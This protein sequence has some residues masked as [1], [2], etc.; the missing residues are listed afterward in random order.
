SAFGYTETYIPGADRS[1]RAVLRLC[2]D[3]DKMLNVHSEDETVK[4]LSELFNNIISSDRTLH[5]CY[6]CGTTARAMFLTLIREYRGSL[7]LT[8][9]E[10]QRMSV[11][12]KP[13][14]GDT[15]HALNMFESLS[16]TLKT[17]DNIVCICS[18]GL[19]QGS[20]HVWILEKR[21]GIVRMYQ[22]ALK[23]HLLIDF[24]EEMDYLHMPHKGIDLRVFLGELE[25]IL[26]AKNWKDIEVVYHQMFA[27]HPKS[28]NDD[29]AIQPSFCYTYIEL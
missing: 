10:K 22:S 17:L 27:Y 3:P 23:S 29:P 20:G 16:D 15:V 13:K 25:S 11:M 21:N 4:F 28:V 6:D 9:H 5:K 19:K 24:V 8:T 14:H 18:I 12:Y 26:K 7:D 2:T 1:L